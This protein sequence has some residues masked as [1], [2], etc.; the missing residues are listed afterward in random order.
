MAV[1]H[2]GFE[3]PVFHGFNGFFVKAHAEAG[4]HANVAGT[5]VGSH[6]Q[7]QGA[8]PLIF[9]FARLFEKLRFGSIDLAR[10]GNA[11]AYM[12]DASTG[13]TAFTWTET[14]ALAG[15]DAAAAAG[16][17][18]ATGACAIRR[19][20]RVQQRIAQVR[21]VVG[22]QLNLRGDYDCGLDCQFGMLVANHHHWRSDLLHRKFGELAARGLKHIAITA[23]TTAAGL[24]L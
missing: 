24:R 14:R 4:Q 3:F 21:Q 23:A 1:F 18:A 10:R 8:D 6:D 2:G 16:T 19:Q 17:N 5:T 13:T 20:Y 11:T 15:P 7:A 22:S 12:E 9:R